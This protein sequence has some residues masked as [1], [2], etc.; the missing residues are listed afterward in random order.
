MSVF[1]PCL[2][3]VIEPV[4]AA[5]GGVQRWGAVVPQGLWRPVERSGRIDVVEGRRRWRRLTPPHRDGL[6]RPADA[7]AP[8]QHQ[9][10]GQ[11]EAGRGVAQVHGQAQLVLGSAGEERVVEVQDDVIGGPGHG[12][13]AEQAGAE[14][15]NRAAHSQ[16][17]LDQGAASEAGALH[18]HHRHQARQHRGEAGEHHEGPGSLMLTGIMWGLN[19]TLKTEHGILYS[20]THLAVN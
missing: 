9:S 18:P 20:C 15:T 2:H 11:A 13:Q 7:A 8:A 10:A 6:T 3:V 14:E 5:G 12:Q 17:G 1:L 4:A 19:S 16:R